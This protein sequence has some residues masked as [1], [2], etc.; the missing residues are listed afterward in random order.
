MNEKNRM[1]HPDNRYKIVNNIAEG[2][3]L[4]VMVNLL[5]IRKDV[6]VG[7]NITIQVD[8]ALKLLSPSWWRYLHYMVA[9]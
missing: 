4:Q 3:I 5:N 2:S 8:A 9:Q 1:S 7:R 6:C